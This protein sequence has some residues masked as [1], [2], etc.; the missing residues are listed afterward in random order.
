MKGTTETWDCI[1]VGAGIAGVCATYL[2]SQRFP[3]WRILLVDKS[4]V[5]TGAT[6]YSAGFGSPLVRNEKLRPLVIRSSQFYAGLRATIPSLPINDISFC[7][8]VDRKNVA[9]FLDLFGDSKRPIQSHQSELAILKL[10]PGLRWPSSEQLWSGTIAMHSKVQEMVRYILLETQ[11]NP[12]VKCW[13]GVTVRSILEGDD[14]I[15]LTT[16]DNRQLLAH[17]GILAMGPWTVSGAAD[18]YVSTFNL[19]RKKV[20]AFHLYLDPPSDAPALYLIDKAI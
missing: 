3:F 1:V 2:A 15:E 14:C 9:S 11:K 18:R 10:L 4:F 7:S 20:V 6:M 17:R 12:L 13:E 19:R 16:T 8:F 5:G